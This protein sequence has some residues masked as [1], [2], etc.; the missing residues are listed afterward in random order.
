MDECRSK[1]VMRLL[2]ANMTPSEERIYYAPPGK[3]TSLIQL[4]THIVASFN[5]P[6]VSTIFQFLFLY[7]K[8]DHYLKILISVI[9][10]CCSQALGNFINLESYLHSWPQFFRWP[11]DV[12][13]NNNFQQWIFFFILYL[14][15]I[16]DGWKLCKNRVTLHH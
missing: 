5:I 12:G 13:L 8:L 2:A 4:I 7:K 3:I 14:G 16:L 9:P 1:A 6:S 15:L 10:N 11:V